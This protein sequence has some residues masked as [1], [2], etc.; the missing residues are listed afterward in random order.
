MKIRSLPHVARSNR[1][2]CS[3]TLPLPRGKGV[4]EASER[5]AD[6]LLEG[7]GIELEIGCGVG[8]HPIEYARKNPDRLVIAIERTT[9]KFNKFSMRLSRHA[10][11]PNLVAVHADAVAWVT[12]FVPAKSL[13]RIFILYPNPNFKNAQAR[14][15]RMPFFR[16]LLEKL[17]AKGVIEFRTNEAAYAEEVRRVSREWGTSLVEDSSY[18]KI[19]V[20]PEIATTHFERKYLER[21]ETCYRLVLVPLN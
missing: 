11:I 13:K 16:A 7:V 8:W 21:G 6:A 17:E 14:W 5:L 19:S 12:H 18:E 10:K 15:I 3:D 9:E 4:L 1:R 20:S 2:F